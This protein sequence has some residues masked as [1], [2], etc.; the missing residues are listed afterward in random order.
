MSA[1][2]GRGTPAPPPML[3]PLQ[4]A[5][6]AAAEMLRVTKRGT[7]N[8]QKRGL[9]HS[10]L[11]EFVLLRLLSSASPGCWDGD[12]VSLSSRPKGRAA[13]A[14]GEA[15]ASLEAPQ[16]TCGPTAGERSAGLR[17]PPRRSWEPFC[18]VPHLGREHG[19]DPNTFRPKSFPRSHGRAPPPD[20]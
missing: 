10:L 9:G 1:T 8:R 18:L 15:L 2:F 7:Q 17:Q 11:R 12:P 20:L 5:P 6:D 19:H 4:A 3:F 14:S 16:M 13:L